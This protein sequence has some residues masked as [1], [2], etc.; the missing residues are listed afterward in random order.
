MY[1]IITPTSTSKLLFFVYIVTVNKPIIWPYAL[2]SSHPINPLSASTLR[3]HP[4]LPPSASTLRF[5][6]LLPPS[7]STL[8]TPL[9]SEDCG[10]FRCSHHSCPC[11]PWYYCFYSQSTQRN[12]KDW[13]NHRSDPGEKINRYTLTCFL[14]YTFPAV[15]AGSGSSYIMPPY[16][17]L[18]YLP[19]QCSTFCLIS[20]SCLLSSD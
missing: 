13:P 12:K 15:S 5:N 10:V 11:C 8:S 20:P 1:P 3:F 9:S 18:L 7:A 17:I 2:Q 19:L 4:P 6:P 14:C 16:L